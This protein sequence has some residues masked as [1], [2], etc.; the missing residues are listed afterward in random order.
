MAETFRIGKLW[1]LPKIR[2]N[3]FKSSENK[4]F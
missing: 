4:L 1:H 3:A 2:R